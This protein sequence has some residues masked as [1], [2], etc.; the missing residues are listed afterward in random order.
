MPNPN[1]LG[2][3]ITLVQDWGL[4]HQPPKYKQNANKQKKLNKGKITNSIPSVQTHIKLI[5]MVQK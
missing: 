5:L 3:Q 4:L 2:L 1:K